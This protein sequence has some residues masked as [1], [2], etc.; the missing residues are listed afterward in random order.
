[1]LSHAKLLK[2]FWGDALLRTNYVQN[3]CP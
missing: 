1:M 3:R 2:V